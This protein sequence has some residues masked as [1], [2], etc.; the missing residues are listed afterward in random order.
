MTT[1]AIVHARQVLRDGWIISVP[2]QGS[3]FKVQGWSGL[4]FEGSDFEPGTLNLEL[5]FA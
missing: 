2:V 5:A 4:K 3:R 1:A